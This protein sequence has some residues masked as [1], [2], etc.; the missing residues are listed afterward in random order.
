MMKNWEI[1]KLG[2]IAKINYGYTE[3]ASYTEVGPRF[4][5]IIDIKNDGVKWCSV[6]YC[7]CCDSDLLK[8]QLEEDDIVFARTGATTGKSFLVKNPPKAVFASYLIRLK[9]ISKQDFSSDFV[10]YYFQTKFYWDK[11]NEGI[12]GSAQGGFNASKLGQLIF[13]IPP[14]QEQKRIV[15]ILDQAFAAIAKAKANAEQN[16]KNAKELFEVYLQGVLT[17]KRWTVVKLGE[18]CKKVEYGSSSKSAPTGDIPVLRMGNIQNR[19]FDWSNLVFSNNKEEN[20]KYLLSHNDVLFNR[21]N[22]PAL[23]GKSAI[24]KSEMPAIFA[25]YLIRIHR[26]EDLLNAD[27]LNYFLNS[28]LAKDYGKKVM[29]SSVNQANINGTKLKEYPLPLPSLIAQQAIVQKLDALSLETKRLEA[30]YQKKIVDLEE[31]KKSI[32]QKAFSGELTSP[33]GA[34]YTSDGYSPSSVMGII[35]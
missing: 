35:Y 1:K 10:S 11:I 3:K 28:S 24:Y 17:D 26:E 20:S 9:L 31:L 8:F 19:R 5:R 2:E 12:S 15:A 34:S 21:T 25:G 22:S 18:V 14:L 16:L 23:V 4:L 30:I 6:P 29:S 33:E 32:L 13:P 27:Y 7:E